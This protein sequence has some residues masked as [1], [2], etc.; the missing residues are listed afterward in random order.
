[1]TVQGASLAQPLSPKLAPAPRRRA[2][3]QRTVDAGRRRS[4]H[5]A[6]VQSVAPSTSPPEPSRESTRQGRYLAWATADNRDK[7]LLAAPTELRINMLDEFGNIESAKGG[8]LAFLR[9]AGSRDAR[10][11]VLKMLKRIRDAHRAGRWWQTQQFI[12]EY[13]TSYDARLAA[14]HRAF[15]KMKPARRPPKDQLP[16]IASGLNAFNGTQEKV[17]LVVRRKRSNPHEFRTTLD[18]GIEN[19]ALQYLVLSV[20]YVIADLHPRQFAVRGGV[21]AAVAHAQGAMQAG[22]VYAREIDI[23]RCFQSFKGDRIKN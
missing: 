17:R 4:W 19:R 21:H 20:L 3:Q 1:V 13:L 18:F 9:C 23:Q 22:F 10:Q 12:R 5:R 16:A 2:F 8:L 11:H 14:T 7:E 6:P 15:E